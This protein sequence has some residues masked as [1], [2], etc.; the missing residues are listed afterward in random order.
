MAS[1]RTTVR[2]LRR[3][4]RSLLLS[5]LYFDGPLSRHELSQL[6][7]L[8]AATVSNVTAELGEERLITEAGQVES[9]GGRPRVL[10]RVDPA[11]GHVAGVDIGETGVKVELFDLA[12][13]RLATAEH[14]LPK[15]PDPAT[16]V[17]QVTSGLREVFADL[18]GSAVLGVGI[19]VPGTVEQGAR[20]LVHAPT[21]GWD[22]VPLVSLLQEA[23]VA[24]PL[25]VDNGAKTQGQAEMWF[26]AG[27][28]ARHAVIA[29]IG[30][31]VGAAVVTDGT[32]YRGSTSSAGEWGHTTIAY[33]GQQC[34]C[35]ARGC[36]EAYIGAGAVLARY[37]RARGKEIAG[38]DEQAQ[39]SA[40]LE[41]AAK[42]KT[43]ARVLEETA[44]Y[45]GAG[46]A[47]LI[48]L[49]NPERIVIGGWAGLAL[50]E[51]LL[52]QIRAAAGEHALRH[53]FSQTSIQLGSLGLDAV[54]TGAATLPVA[55]LLAQGA[56]SRL[57][58]PGAP[59][60]DAA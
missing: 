11:Y 31:G 40:L 17:E 3:H 8:S 9:D 59:D 10:L 27:R 33:G 35:G 54:A 53:P 45:L 48:N 22:A 34:R 58:K 19:G 24:L 51:K 46:I 2:D 12:M 56:T 30:S 16:A 26:G 37:R 32:T 14:P 23:G 7:G 52:P 15:A 25:F 41:A 60:S 55:D 38:E 28:G 6:T 13:N 21:V 20:V 43:A 50:G 49:F 29:L 39:F 44:G 18:D 47:N 4:N 5:K 42:S 36:L 1:K 57:A